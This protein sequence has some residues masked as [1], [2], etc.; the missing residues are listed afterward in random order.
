MRPSY[1]FIFLLVLLNGLSYGLQAQADSTIVEIPKTSKSKVY[2]LGAAGI[3]TGA[4]FF[5]DER[6]ER[7]LRDASFNRSRFVRF[8]DYT[9][10]TFMLGIPLV[11]WVAGKG[12]NDEPLVQTSYRA[13]AAA[14]SAYMLTAGLKYSVGRVRPQSEINS[15]DFRG[16]HRDDYT[17]FV[18]GHS[19]VA[20][21]LA[22][23]FAQSYGHRAALPPLFYATAT[24]IS[25][26][27]VAA[28]EHWLS[29]V[30]TGAALGMAVGL[31]LNKRLQ[32]EGVQMTLNHTPAGGAGM[33][34]LYTF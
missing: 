8:G 16:F 14:L 11:T 17:S 31:W 34:L 32:K 20:F 6:L 27:R 13:G 9:R 33:G 23:V 24:G 29:D 26:S 3:I 7:E 15:R 10:A 25:L 5:F 21:S 2:T 28:G 12:F 18:S 1:C 22:T 19:S 30:T 4:S